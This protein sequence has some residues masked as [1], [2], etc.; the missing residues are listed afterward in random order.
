MPQKVREGQIM[1]TP[2]YSMSIIW[3]DENKIL[4]VTVPE[5]DGCMTHG[6]TYEE[7]VKNGEDAINGWI[8]VAQQLG[9]P[10]PQSR[11]YADTAA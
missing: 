9:W 10:L 3:D 6:K 7:A 4:V 1:N 5:L 11:N 8:E 2:H